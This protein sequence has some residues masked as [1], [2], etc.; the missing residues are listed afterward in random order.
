MSEKQ[1]KRPRKPRTILEVAVGLLARREHSATEL[2]NKLKQRDFTASE[3]ESVLEQLQS[4]NYLDDERFVDAFVSSR[5]SRGHGPLKIR[6]ELK[7]RGVASGLIDKYVN[8]RDTRWFE[9][10][11]EV[12]RK[13]FGNLPPASYEDKVKVWRFMQSRGFSQDQFERASRTE[14]VD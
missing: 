14:F 4:C 8:D 13:K 1:L 10:A 11:A 5:I 12:Y 7:Q 2:A 9:A 3:I 6:M